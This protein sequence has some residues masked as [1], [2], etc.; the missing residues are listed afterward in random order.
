MLYI[1]HS[2]SQNSKDSVWCVYSAILENSSQNIYIKAE[3]DFDTQTPVQKGP[4]VIL[5]DEDLRW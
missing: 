1:G 5:C 2:I 4:A 3:L